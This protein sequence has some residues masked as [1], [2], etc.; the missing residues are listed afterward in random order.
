M[1]TT[2]SPLVSI[3]IPI[4]NVEQYV[5]ECLESVRQQ[6]YKKLEIIVVEDCSTDN[7]LKALEPHLADERVRLIQHKQ[8]GGLS[9]ARNTGIEA[10]TGE[11]LMFVDSD[12]VVERSLVEVCT[13]AA[14]RLNADVITYGCIPFN[15]GEPIQPAEVDVERLE[16][17]CK[18]SGSEYFELPHFAWLKFVRAKLFK[19]SELRFPVGLCYED[20]PFHW[21]LGLM[22]P[23]I[24]RI[25]AGLYH[26]RQRGTSITGSAGIKL[27]DVFQ[28]QAMA[29][30]M[31]GMSDDKVVKGALCNK[32]YDSSWRV[33][34]RIDADLLPLAYSE[35]KKVIVK[36]RGFGF[37]PKYNARRALIVTALYMPDF[38]GLMSIY[39]LRRSLHLI[40]VF[41]N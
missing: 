18:R 24:F 40:S 15:D 22:A 8:N 30:N 13:R 2:R 26:Y 3:V 36:V 7:S 33:L 37:Y 35:S 10:A 17:S 25:E 4:Y 28:V 11:Y 38:L 34:T 9:A 6:T 27:L 41:D 29:V 5:D 31:V 1:S 16:K 20:W 23:S 14:Q 39:L 32:L 12:D 19:D 21:R